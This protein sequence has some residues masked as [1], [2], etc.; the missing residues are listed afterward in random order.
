MRWLLLLLSFS[1]PT[2]IL[3]AQRNEQLWLEYQV[4]YPY[5]NGL[6][7]ENTAAY[8]TILTTED[9]WW[10]FSISPTV[11]YTLF[12]WVDLTA[13]VGVAYTLQKEGSNSFEIAPM[14][15]GRF[16]ITQN[17]RISS[18]VLLRYQ[19][20]NFRQIEADD[21]DTGNRVRLKGEIW[22]SL[23]GPNLFTDKLWYALVDYEEFLVIDEQLDERFANRR[24]ARI[25]VGYRLNYKNRFDFIYTRQSSR[26]E[27]DGEFN[28]GDNVFQLR[29]KM[30]LNPAKITST[31]Q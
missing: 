1:I 12:T 8:Q 4:D 14:L 26:N 31:D 27:I 25:G 18:R 21:W 24:R 10:S 5:A 30:F 19:Q 3:F 29:Y 2:R 15:G 6:L 13:E 22:I 11:E 28:P 16:H 17:K 20:R 23:N 7:L 9:K